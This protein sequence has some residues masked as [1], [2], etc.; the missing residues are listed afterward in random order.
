MRLRTKEKD[1]K[2]DGG[3]VGL[4]GSGWAPF[5]LSFFFLCKLLLLF[6]RIFLGKQ[7]GG[8]AKICKKKVQ[9]TFKTRFIVSTQIQRFANNIVLVLIQNKRR[10]GGFVS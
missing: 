4:H 6:C 3:L 2:K 8:F 1:D 5:L 7:E 10:R 9:P